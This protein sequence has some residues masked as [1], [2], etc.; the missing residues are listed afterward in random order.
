[1]HKKGTEAN[2]RSQNLVKIFS[3][4]NVCVNPRGDKLLEYNSTSECNNLLTFWLFTFPARQYQQMKNYWKS[5]KYWLQC[6]A[7]MYWIEEHWQIALK[8]ICT[9]NCCSRFDPE[10]RTLHTNAGCRIVN[11]PNLQHLTFKVIF[12]LNDANCVPFRTKLNAFGDIK[13]LVECAQRKS[14]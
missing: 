3:M 6:W 10:E 1:M 2:Y 4:A 7:A 13:N 5:N 14:N 8:F 9:F 11:H 12:W